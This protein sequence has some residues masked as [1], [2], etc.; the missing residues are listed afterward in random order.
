MLALCHLFI[1]FLHF[2]K[3]EAW[4]L[5]CHTVTLET[6]CAVW[7]VGRQGSGCWPC[8]RSKFRGRNREDWRTQPWG[9]TETNCRAREATKTQ[10]N[11]EKKTALA[12]KIPQCRGKNQTMH[13]TEIIFIQ[14]CLAR[15]LDSL[16]IKTIFIGVLV[17]NPGH[18]V[19]IMTVK[20]NFRT[21]HFSNSWV[22]LLD[23][24]MS[25]LKYTEVLYS[26]ICV[27]GFL[28]HLDK[29][30]SRHRSLTEITLHNSARTCPLRLRQRKNRTVP[31]AYK[32]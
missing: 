25:S 32:T 8:R 31:L 3:R 7:R 15:R 19:D 5:M 24:A 13:F 14:T 27:K 16:R 21:K 18:F 23:P 29:R 20:F 22:N 2:K 10:F 26:F 30:I 9:R 11:A 4:G 12:S 17:F 1:L 28:C 6:S